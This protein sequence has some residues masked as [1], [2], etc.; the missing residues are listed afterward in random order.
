MSHPHVLLRSF[1]SLLHSDP[2]GCARIGG[3]I[4]SRDAETPQGNRYTNI[5]IRDAAPDDARAVADIWNYYICYTL[6][7]NFAENGR[8]CG[9]RY[10]RATGA[11]HG[12][13][14][15][16]V[17]WALLALLPMGNSRRGICAYNGTYCNYTLIIWR[18]GR[19]GNHG[20]HIRTRQ[21]PGGPFHVRR[22][23]FGNLARCSFMNV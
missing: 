8:G 10:H 16:K 18:W 12:F 4:I 19:T 22:R 2:R 6:T 23:Q 14:W 9:H 11:G 17:M 5:V 1:L 21:S 15:R 3:A 20:A 7:F 13:L